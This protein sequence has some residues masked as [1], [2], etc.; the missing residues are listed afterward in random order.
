M[1]TQMFNRIF[2]SLTTMLVIFGCADDK[3][4]AQTKITDKKIELNTTLEKIV[5]DYASL[6]IAQSG[7]IN[8]DI[9]S[10]DYYFDD[11]L[12]TKSTFQSIEEKNSKLQASLGKTNAIASVHLLKDG[13]SRECVIVSNEG[14]SINV[15]MH[16]IGHCFTPIRWTVPSFSVKNNSKNYDDF[17]NELFADIAVSAITYKLE[18]NFSYM[19]NRLREIQEKDYCAINYK[20]ATRWFE[21]LKAVLQ[22]RESFDLSN[23]IL[24]E[25]V[26][27]EVAK[28][29]PPYTEKEYFDAVDKYLKVFKE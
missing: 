16:E 6:K 22:Q 23:E 5:G 9:S 18:N 11:K 24:V 25:E 4:A 1:N 28:K 12:K 15:L 29:H 7:S 19:N 27:T 21:S 13:K 2:L 17:L 8:Q 10:N 26:L 3:S 20:F 14:A